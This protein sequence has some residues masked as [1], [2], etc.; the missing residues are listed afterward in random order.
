MVGGSIYSPDGTTV[1]EGAGIQ[2]MSKRDYKVILSVLK[3]FESELEIK[4][5]DKFVENDILYI[6]NNGKSE[7]YKFRNFIKINS[8]E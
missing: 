3:K 6:T 7:E 4:G 1:G 5:L 8:T 2:D